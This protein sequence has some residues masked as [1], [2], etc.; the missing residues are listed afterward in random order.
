MLFMANSIPESPLVKDVNNFSE[1]G[2]IT[3][4]ASTSEPNNTGEKDSIDAQQPTTFGETTPNPMTALVPYD[5]DCSMPYPPSVLAGEQGSWDEP[6]Q[7]PD[8]P[9]KPHA[10][11]TF[12]VPIHIVHK[13]PDSAL[14]DLHRYVITFILVCHLKICA[15]SCSS[16]L[17]RGTY[18]WIRRQKCIVLTP[19]CI[20]F[21]LTSICNRLMFT[22][23]L[24]VIHFFI[25][26]QKQI[27]R[28]LRKYN[29]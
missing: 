19:E 18:F 25:V 2:S 20:R 7:P 21:L 28:L 4:F 6:S 1:P 8:E 14:I 23:Y 17:G 16:N 24:T 10:K 26:C 3:T 12:T 5:F 22:K 9:E 27:R 15:Y 29:R 11:A 13:L